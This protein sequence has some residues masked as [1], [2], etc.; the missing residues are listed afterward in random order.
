MSSSHLL[1]SLSPQKMTGKLPCHHLL[2]LHSLP[3]PV[4]PAMAFSEG[5]LTWMAAAPFS[6]SFTYSP[7][8]FYVDNAVI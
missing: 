2:I 4:Q 1:S 7:P 6:L 8:P 3:S 5:G